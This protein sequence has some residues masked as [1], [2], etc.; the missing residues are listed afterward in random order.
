MTC[1]HVKCSSC[2]AL[3]CLIIDGVRSMLTFAFI[4]HEETA[5]RHGTGV[6]KVGCHFLHGSYHCIRVEISGEPPSAAPGNDDVG[7]EV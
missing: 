5:I 3:F 7:C 1:S 4:V 2:S 6:L